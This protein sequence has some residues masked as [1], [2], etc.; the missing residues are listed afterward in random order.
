[1]H[2]KAETFK[3]KPPEKLEKEFYYEKLAFEESKDQINQSATSSTDMLDSLQKKIFQEVKNMHQMDYLDLI[4]YQGEKILTKRDKSA[5]VSALANKG[6]QNQKACPVQSMPHPEDR[7]GKELPESLTST[8][9]RSFEN[10]FDM[11]NE[12]DI[13]KLVSLT[14]EHTEV[15]SRLERNHL[16]S[17]YEEEMQMRNRLGSF[18]RPRV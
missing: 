11:K 1:L 6:G 3:P 2:S 17:N 14:K 13:Q 10:G 16:F 7:N 9:F 15:I 18:F 5:D 4:K 12:E 8:Q